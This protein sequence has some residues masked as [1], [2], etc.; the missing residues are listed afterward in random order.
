MARVLRNRVYETSTTTG[1][2]AITLD[3]AYAA[4]F[5]TFYEAGELIV[6]DT[7][8]YVI[9][10]S[11]AQPTWYE[12]GEGTLLTTTTFSRDV[13]DSTNNNALVDLPAG[14]HIVFLSP[15]ASWLSTLATNA[16]VDDAIADAL[17][18]YYTATQT[19]SAISSALVPY[20]TTVSVT[21]AINTALIPYSTSAQINTLLGDYLTITNA[22]ATYATPASVTTQINNAT[23]LTSQ[24]S[25]TLAIGQFADNVITSA[26]IVSLAASKLTGAVAPANGGMGADTSSLTG[27][28]K[29]TAGVPS[30]AVA[31]T[32]YLTTVNWASPGALGSTTPNTIAGTT[33]TFSG[34]LAVDT[35]V[36]FVDTTNDRVGVG[37]NSSLLGKLHVY[38]T[39]GASQFYMTGHASGYPLFLMGGS[40][41]THAGVFRRIKP[42]AD[43]YFGEDGD[44]GSTVFRG[45]G[46]F[47]ATSAATSART[48]LFVQNTAGSGTTNYARIALGPHGGYDFSN[49]P[50]MEAFNDGNDAGLAWGTYNSGQFE[51]MRL[52]KE[53]N[54]FIGTP[55]AA[56]GAKL[57]VN[58]LASSIAVIARQNSTPGTVNIQEWQNSGGTPL[59]S[60]DYLGGG[61]FTGL[62]I[63]QTP[64][65][66]TP[67][68]THTITVNLNG[69][70]YRIPCV[71]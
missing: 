32:D 29:F 2:G 6:G 63:D 12:A 14:T 62:R 50:Y 8:P 60:V 13:E 4:G 3:G 7:F 11:L 35:N 19:N 41:N 45:S 25:G 57:H 26:K 70:N 55:N 44:T 18:P 52:S 24:L 30:V 56:A 47:R 46:G 16:D 64:V 54:L 71:I 22:A 58:A 48:T 37:I 40:S 53:G 27:I 17:V 9:T 1:T 49:P 61:R 67:T 36:L 39:V 5:N 59:A 68:P 15:L 10:D 31:G 38:D 28:Y 43:L 21:S 42:A 65:A 34:N 23:I 20:A 66:A 69:T 51:R 33:G